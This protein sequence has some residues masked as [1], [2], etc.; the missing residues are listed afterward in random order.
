MNNYSKHLTPEKKLMLSLNL[1]YAAKELKKAALKKF[2]PA[3]SENEINENL[4]R[5]FFMQDLNLYIVILLGA[6]WQWL[7][8]NS[9][10]R[11]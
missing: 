5:Y 10:I 6:S 9:C 11:A 7:S 8:V 1:Y 3:L 4:K 2:Y